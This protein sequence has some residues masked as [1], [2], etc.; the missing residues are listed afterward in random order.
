MKKLVLLLYMLVGVVLSVRSQAV[1]NMPFT[2]NP[3]LTVS[4][5]SAFLAFQEPGMELG[6]DLVITGGSGTYRYRWTSN[7]AEL[8]TEPTLY[9]TAMGVYSL[10]IFDTCDCEQTVTF[11]VND[12]SGIESLEASACKV[13]PNPA[14]DYLIVESG[15]GKEM[16]QV[17]LVAANGQLVKVFADVW[18]SKT[19]LSL[20][21]IAPGQYLLNCVYDDEKVATSVIWIK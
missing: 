10:E 19:M 7:G 9:V 17:S 12:G 2:Q 15:T 5:Q 18:G 6:A 13:Y 14:A 8:G 21:G 3:A 4:T 11:H 20:D 1:I 16:K